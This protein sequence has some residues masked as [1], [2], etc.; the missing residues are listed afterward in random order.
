MYLYYLYTSLFFQEIKECVKDLKVLGIRDLRSLKKWQDSL[1]K[2]FEAEDALNPP[3]VEEAGPAVEKT[4]EE[5]EDGELEEIDKKISE[6]KVSLQNLFFLV[7]VE[8]MVKAL[9]QGWAAD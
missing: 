7:S 8:S 5:I 6:L 2:E 1:R 3:V 9:K 4:Q